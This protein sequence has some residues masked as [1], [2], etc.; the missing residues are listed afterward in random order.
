MLKRYVGSLLVGII[1]GLAAGLFWGWE[2]D[3]VEYKNS[4]LDALA[5]HYKENYTVM[6]ADGY[7]VDRDVS[8]ALARLQ[9]LG[10]D[11]VPDYVQDLTERYISQSNVPVIPQMV[12]LAEAMGRL[13]PI[14]EIY[15][16]TPAPPSP[17]PEA[18]S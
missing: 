8:A 5:P 16:V 9:L 4:S 1:V 17:A 3:P 11:N 7:Q 14:M 12:A 6:V 13:T 18:G 2:L 10:Y 15:R